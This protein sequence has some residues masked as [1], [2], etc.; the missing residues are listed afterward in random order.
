MHRRNTTKKRQG[1]S[2][3]FICFDGIIV[4]YSFLE[5]L[6]SKVLIP[7]AQIAARPEHLNWEQIID[8]QIDSFDVSWHPH[9]VDIRGELVCRPFLFCHP[10]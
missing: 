3:A 9:V 4:F 8:N 7:M 1:I 6:C 2:H 10:R 5:T